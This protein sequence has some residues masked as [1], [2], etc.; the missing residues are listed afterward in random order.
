MLPFG[1]VELNDIGAFHRR[2]PT[3]GWANG[4]PR[5]ATTLVNGQGQTDP[6]IVPFFTV[7]VTVC[8]KILT[9]N[10]F[11]NNNIWKISV[12]INFAI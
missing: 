10:V 1:Y 11:T 12:Y 3:G 5:Y 8:A 2:D 6:N 9:T 4:I 7:T